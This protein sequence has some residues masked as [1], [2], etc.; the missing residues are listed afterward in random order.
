M[1]TIEVDDGKRENETCSGIRSRAT[2][3]DVD[4]DAKEEEVVGG[5][6][7]SVTPSFG[8]FDDDIVEDSSLT[9]RLLWFLFFIPSPSP[10]LLRFLITLPML[11]RL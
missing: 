8:C 2:V 6:F 4:V 7:S 1:N 11:I 5:Q 3:A 9:Q 10:T